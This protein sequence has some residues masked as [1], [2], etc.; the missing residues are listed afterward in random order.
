[1]VRLRVGRGQEVGCVSGSAGP[2]VGAE[3]VAMRVCADDDAVVLAGLC[4]FALAHGWHRVVS[5]GGEV[6]GLAWRALIL[7]SKCCA[8]W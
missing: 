8:V 5:E 7:A 1:M 4:D 6:A 3:E 2:G